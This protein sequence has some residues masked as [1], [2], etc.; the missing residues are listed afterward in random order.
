[1]QKDSTK[2]RVSTIGVVY[3]CRAAERKDSF[4][5][6]VESYKSNAANC[7]HD[8][9]VIFKGFEGLEHQR[10]QV[11]EIF[12]DLEYIDYNMADESFDIGSYLEV[13]KYFNYD[14]LFF[15]NTHTCILS[16]NWLQLM[17]ATIQSPSVGLV[18]TTASYES[19]F[20]SYNFFQYFIQLYQSGRISKS[21]KS[22]EYYRSWIN[23]LGPVEKDKTG[24]KYK[25]ID[26]IK[27]RILIKN[28]IV[29]DEFTLELEKNH[30]PF[31][32]PH[33][34]SNGF[35]ISRKLLVDLYGDF[36][37]TV[38]NDAYRFESGYSSLTRKILKMNLR[39]VIV[40]RNGVSYDMLDWP[41][42]NT[43][44][45][46]AQSN[47]LI[48]DNQTSCFEKISDKEKVLY[49]WMKWGFYDHVNEEFFHSYGFNKIKNSKIMSNL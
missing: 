4:V 24:I 14:Y 9:I 37:I 27:R 8:L 10:E 16:Q 29:Q 25:I 41:T 7:E 45:L 40:G 6:F 32:N 33:I 21:C 35:L 47:L 28:S 43:F 12:S 3:L 5:K 18:G 48:S 11:K 19:L 15:A 23:T 42:S 13:A 34:R 49:S 2:N 1:M 39:P 20:T 46:G 22:L 36:K 44:G 30:P 26:F 38:K 17:Y 31:P